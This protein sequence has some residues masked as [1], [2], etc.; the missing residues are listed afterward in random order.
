MNC[1]EL[2]LSFLNSVSLRLLVEFRTVLHLDWW[3]DLEVTWDP[4]S[5]LSLSFFHFR[6]SS[7]DIRTR[8]QL[9]SE[10]RL[11]NLPVQ[12][13]RQASSGLAVE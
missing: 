12:L 7:T 11:L 5:S 6:I 10:L 8:R 4:P 3:K 13:L 1:L 9:N 2:D